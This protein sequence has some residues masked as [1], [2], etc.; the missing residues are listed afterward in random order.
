MSALIWN[1]EKA[2]SSPSRSFPQLQTNAEGLSITHVMMNQARFSTAV[3]L[4][5][6]PTMLFWG[7]LHKYIQ[8]V[9]MFRN[10]FNKTIIDLVALYQILMR[11]VT[12]PAKTLLSP[13]FLVTPLLIVTRRQCKF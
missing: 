6:A 10:S 12:G 7:E 2:E 8:F 5:N 11:D 13:A 4:G 3:Q 1:D 9:T